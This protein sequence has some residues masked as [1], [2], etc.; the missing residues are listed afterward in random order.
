MELFERFTSPAA[1]HY[2]KQNVLGAAAIAYPRHRAVRTAF[3]KKQEPVR[4][5]LPWRLSAT[6]R[7]EN[8]L[9]PAPLQRPLRTDSLHGDSTA[10]S[11]WG[12]SI[13]GLGS[14]DFGSNQIG[15]CTLT[16]RGPID[17]ARL[18]VEHPMPTERAEC[19]A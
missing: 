18:F 13:K 8:T 2:A 7:S 9:T 10:I 14:Q 17:C 12:G 6:T 16:A 11:C 1:P 19:K 5:T 15:K 3:S 4:S